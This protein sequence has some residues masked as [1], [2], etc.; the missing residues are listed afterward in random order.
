MGVA[1]QYVNSKRIH[2]GFLVLPIL[3]FQQVRHNYLRQP[4]T[5]LPSQ[6]MKYLS[7]MNSTS[8][9]AHNQQQMDDCIRK[10]EEFLYEVISSPAEAPSW[11]IFNAACDDDGRKLLQN[12]QRLVATTFQEPID[13]DDCCSFYDPSMKPF[14][15]RSRDAVK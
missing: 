7:R 1:A 14:V 15:R 13:D 10:Y 5:T 8:L 12:D 4:S 2:S 6:A 9:S 3:S 11:V